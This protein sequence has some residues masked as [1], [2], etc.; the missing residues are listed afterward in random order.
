MST[1]SSISASVRAQRRDTKYSFTALAVSKASSANALEPASSGKVNFVKPS[2]LPVR[3]SV[4]PANTPA[5]TSGSKCQFC[6]KYFA[7]NHGMTTHL[8]EKCEKIPASV[9]RTLLQKKDN[10]DEIK[11]KQVSRH[12]THAFGQDIDSISKYSRFFVNVSN[13]GASGMPSD[14]VTGIDVENG[15]KNLRA[16]L[17]KIKSVHTGI[18]RTPSKPLRCHICKKIFFDCVEY[19]EHSSSGHSKISI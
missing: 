1:R 17:R 10:S 2:G 15:L 3:K 11:S 5:S 18:I 12:R 9:R 7:K 8:L 4:I 19:A 14:D 16:E 13:G 6:D